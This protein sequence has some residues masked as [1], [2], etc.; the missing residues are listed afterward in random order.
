MYEKIV[1]YFESNLCI[2]NVYFR[3]KNVLWMS[4][5]IVTF[6]VE[7]IINYVI[8]SFIDNMCT[9][10]VIILLIDFLI[11]FIFFILAYI[12]PVNKIYK[13]KIKEKTELDWVGILM[14]E[15]R[16]SAY[17]KIEI[18]EMEE[19]LKNKCKINNI[20]SINII[21]DMINEEIEYRYNKTNFMDKYLNSIILPVLIMVLTIY[22]T[23]INEK[24]FAN[25]LVM[26][27]ISLISIIVVGSSIINI[28]IIPINKKENLL[29]LKRVL[30]DIK[31][32]WSKR[33]KE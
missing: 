17:R 11:A 9:K 1:N 8:S 16:L 31:I 3:E 23:N 14:N 6:L 33:C 25:I 30:M 20:E 27:I 22:F 18:K 12:L 2:A 19:F 7:F 32:E 13:A 4:V 15:E 28:N 21:I 5:V 26:T 24:N 29:E 10:I